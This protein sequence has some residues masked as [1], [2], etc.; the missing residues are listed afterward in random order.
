V[1]AFSLGVPEGISTSLDAA[2][3]N[4][5]VTAVVLIGAGPNIYR[6]RGHTGIRKK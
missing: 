2:A 4:P 6:W 3:K 1:N 5:D